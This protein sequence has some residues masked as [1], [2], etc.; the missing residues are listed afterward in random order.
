M[1]DRQTALDYTL[2]DLTQ[3]TQGAIFGGLFA[4]R[5]QKGMPPPQPLHPL[6]A[7]QPGRA[8]SPAWWLVQ[9]VEFDPEPLTVTKL[10]RRAVYTAPRMAQAL[11]D[12]MMAADW[13][14]RSQTGEYALTPTGKELAEKMLS[15]SLPALSEIDGM[16]NAN[17]G[18]LAELMEDI[19]SIWLADTERDSW[20]LAHSRRRALANDAPNLVK[21]NQFCADF[22][23]YRDDAH[24]AGWRDLGVSGICWELFSLA[25]AGIANDLEELYGQLAHRGY[26]RTELG[27]CLTHLA[28][29]GWLTH[30]EGS[31]IEATAAGIRQR[32]LVE[33]A[34]DGYFYAA[35]GGLPA[36]TPIEL[37]RLLT[38]LQTALGEILV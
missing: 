20:C 19:V 27:D 30:H 18:R 24:M 5:K 9:A 6:L 1:S 31:R 8:E 10:R 32:D 14:D 21:I 17:T 38:E 7:I 28:E 3:A 26:S 15:R 34:T 12:L 4:W 33:A 25:V 11:L 16:L 35:W 36:E 23:A 22:N 13:F 29:R 37:K 2:Y